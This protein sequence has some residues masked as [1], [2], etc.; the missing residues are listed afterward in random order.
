MLLFDSI[1]LS[2]YCNIKNIYLC[3]CNTNIFYLFKK[4]ENDIVIW[5]EL[6]TKASVL[7]IKE[8]IAQ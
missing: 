7:V 3:I 6:R 5:N 1:I 8:F 2:F 4:Y